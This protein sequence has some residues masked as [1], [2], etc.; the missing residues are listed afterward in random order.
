M[1]REKKMTL[2]I[3]DGA[4]ERREHTGKPDPSECALRRS[5]STPASD[6]NRSEHSLEAARTIMPSVTANQT[7]ASRDIAE[8]PKQ[9]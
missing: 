3:E 1:R 5:S 4:R 7:R 8:K 9:G 6:P 2:T